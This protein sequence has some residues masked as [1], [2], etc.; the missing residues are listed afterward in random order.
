MQVKL[1]GTP[2][3]LQTEPC[4][5]FSFL[6]E[7]IF[8]LCLTEKA[9]HEC[10]QPGHIEAGCNAF[11]QT[12]VYCFCV[13]TTDIITCSVSWILTLNAYLQPVQLPWF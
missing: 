8:N 11:D 5:K 3:D 10:E 6:S 9:P 1:S 13:S 4:S 7:H 12:Y 2:L